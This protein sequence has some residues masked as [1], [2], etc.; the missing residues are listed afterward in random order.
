MTLVVDPR[1][2]VRAVYDEA[3][4][5]AA[6]QVDTVLGSQDIAALAEAPRDAVVA[7]A[8]RLQTRL[9]V[10][11]QSSL[12]DESRQERN[13][14]I[15][16]LESSWRRFVQRTSQVGWAQLEPVRTLARQIEDALARLR[17]EAAKAP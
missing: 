2:V 16:D 14:A 12:G 3:V 7:D 4:D 6:R 5:L 8:R 11:R 1:G 15:A 13:Q 17:T 9:Y 10:A